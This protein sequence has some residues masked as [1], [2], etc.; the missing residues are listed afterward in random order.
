[1]SMSKVNRAFRE[2]LGG[3]ATLNRCVMAWERSKGGVQRQRLSCL[4]EPPGG[5]F[6]TVSGL[7]DGRADLAEAARKL[8]A[9]YAEKIK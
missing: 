8:A 6:E 7:F 5:G 9:D 2:G 4:V 1:M 3:K